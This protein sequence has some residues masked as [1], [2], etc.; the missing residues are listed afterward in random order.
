MVDKKEPFIKAV[1]WFLTCGIPNAIDLHKRCG[2]ELM[3][4]LWIEWDIARM[5]TDA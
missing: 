5:R 4:A 3:D 1:W 2:Y